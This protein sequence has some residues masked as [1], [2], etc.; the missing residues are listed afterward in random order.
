[1]GESMVDVIPGINAKAVRI[2][3]ERDL[4]QFW[5]FADV[6]ATKGGQLVLIPPK[7]FTIGIVDRDYHGENWTGGSRSMT[8]STRGGTTELRVYAPSGNTLGSITVDSN[9]LKAALAN[10]VSGFPSKPAGDN[11]MS[12]PTPITMRAD[13]ATSPAPQATAPSP[14]SSQWPRLS[15]EWFWQLFRRELVGVCTEHALS[16]SRE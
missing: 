6:H 10:H 13:V 4:I 8:V 9:K 12:N 15:P 5:I 3:I 2:S 1:M 11:P 16:S 14:I 7:E